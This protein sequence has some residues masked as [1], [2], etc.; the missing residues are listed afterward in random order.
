VMVE[1][2]VML[3]P[4]IQSDISS[5]TAAPAGAVFLLMVYCPTGVFTEAKPDWIFEIIH[6]NE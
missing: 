6:S 2:H 5:S 3:S 4:W 1:N